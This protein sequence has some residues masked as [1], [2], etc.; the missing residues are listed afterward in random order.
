MSSKA[1][2][3]RT[4]TVYCASSRSAHPDYASDARTLG[5]LLAEAGA[6]IC[7]G[8]GG[9]GSMGALARGALDAGG[10]VVGVIP[11]FMAALEWAHET[12][13]ELVLVDTMPERK[14]HMIDAASAVLALP[15]GSG[16]YEELLEVIS[17]K[18]LGLYFGP[19]LLVN[20]RGSFDHLV[21]A[22]EHSIAERFMDERHREMWR[23][24]A[25]PAEA[26]A[27]IVSD[28]GWDVDARSFATL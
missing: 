11:R 12:L 5:R 8:G 13:S 2:A 1:L 20:T 9:R 21:A 14:Q 28:P 4:V 3:G 18:R 17:L 10:L 22:L 15:G 7:Y 16:T 19:I 24:V 25:S 26:L 23:V 27:A 6:A